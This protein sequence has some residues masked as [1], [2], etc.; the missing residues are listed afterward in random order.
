MLSYCCCCCCFSASPRASFA[1]LQLVCLI[2]KRKQNNVKPEVNC[3]SIHLICRCVFVR[4]MRTL[5]W[6]IA[7]MWISS[8]L[9]YT[10][11]FPSISFTFFRA[12]SLSLSLLTKPFRYNDL[13]ICPVL[14]FFQNRN[15]NKIVSRMRNQHHIQSS[16]LC[17]TN[18]S[19]KKFLYGVELRDFFFHSSLYFWK[20]SW[21]KIE[22]QYP[23]PVW[24]GKTLTTKKTN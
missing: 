11:S 16:M 20:I 2:A 17:I 3:L 24:A 5:I 18:K 10:Q 15:D 8:A 6:C 1:S 21:M 13:N 22:F 7:N 19:L 9:Y 12:L 23:M 4:V 14:E